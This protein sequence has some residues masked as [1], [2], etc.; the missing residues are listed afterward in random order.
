MHKSADYAVNAREL[1]ALQDRQQ[2][3]QAQVFYA[4]KEALREM[5][6]FNL[7]EVFQYTL[8][9]SAQKRSLTATLSD[10]QPTP[11]RAVWR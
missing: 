3:I 11:R 9:P 7:L 1:Q 5:R 10:P 8:S 6:P 2:R 4:T